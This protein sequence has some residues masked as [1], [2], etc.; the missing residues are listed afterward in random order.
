LRSAVN[1]LTLPPR[2]LFRALDDLHALA[3]AARRLPDIERTL[4]DRFERLEQRA[5]AIEDQLGDALDLGA[6][7]DRRGADIVALGRRIDARADEI[8]EVG[9]G[10]HERGAELL[11]EGEIIAERAREVAV[12]GSELVAAFPTLERTAQ[13]GETLAQAVEPLQGAAERLGRVVDR[14]PG[15]QRA[16]RPR[17]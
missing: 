16:T 3:E 6:K 10:L 14:L 1:P 8:L 5:D 2:L 9:R 15:G 7:I 13:I 4:I 11:A 17:G 12:T